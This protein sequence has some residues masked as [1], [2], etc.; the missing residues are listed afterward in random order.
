MTEWKQFSVYEGYLQI[1]YENGLT[2]EVT[3]EVDSE[4]GEVT[5]NEVRI[6]NSEF[7]S[8]LHTVVLEKKD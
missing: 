3:A 7:E 5:T 2:M 4:T 1:V 6:R 8:G